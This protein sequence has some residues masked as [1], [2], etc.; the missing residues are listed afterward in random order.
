VRFHRPCCIPNTCKLYGFLKTV[1]HAS[2]MAQIAA[3]GLHQP[4]RAYVDPLATNWNTLA[5]ISN[6]YS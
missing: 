4:K 2:K 3:G 1:L 6:V 5:S